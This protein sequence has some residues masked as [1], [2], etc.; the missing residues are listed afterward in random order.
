MVKAED[1]TF[2]LT[3]SQ[4]TDTGLTSPSADS[5]MP[6]AWQGSHWSA[7][8]EVTGMTR[9]RKSRR[10]RDSNPGSSAPEGDALTTRPTRRWPVRNDQHKAEGRRQKGV[11]NSPVAHG[12]DSS[13][14]SYNR[15]G[16]YF[17][18]LLCGR[19]YLRSSSSSPPPPPPAQPPRWP[20]G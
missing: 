1:Q 8:F 2:Y 13:F 17:P 19:A 5:I 3:Q 18:S 11:S 20:S 9:P 6:G 15:E 7:N 4:Y 16:P 12:P 14:S 10:K